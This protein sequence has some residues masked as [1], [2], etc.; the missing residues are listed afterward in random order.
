MNKDKQE[1][2]YR[3]LGSTLKRLRQRLQETVAEVSG[4]VEI[5]AHHLQAIEQGKE[6]PPEEI[7]LLLISHFA[8]K[9]DEATKLWDL[10]GYDKNALPNEWM[11]DSDTSKPPVYVMPMDVRIAYTD[12]VHVMANNYG[13]VVNFMQGAGPNNQPMI[14]SRVGMSKEHAQS[15]IELLQRTL[16]RLEPKQLPAPADQASQEQSPTGETKE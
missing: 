14:V 3:D 16:Q 15:L 12:M 1:Y 9:E 2:P 7:L 6:R 11:R 10:A 8:V 4:A 13:V 5:E